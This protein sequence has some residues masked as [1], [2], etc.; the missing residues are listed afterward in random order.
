[1]VEGGPYSLIESGSGHAHRP[2][3]QVK[4]AVTQLTIVIPAPA[5]HAPSSVTPQVCR[6]ACVDLDE[7]DPAEDLPRRDCPRG[8]ASFTPSWDSWFD[9]HTSGG[10]CF[11][12]VNAHLW[13]H[14]RHR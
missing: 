13:N 12:R 10:T 8:S 3:R 5:E 7:G 6:I 2:D 11:S 1:V 4:R 9:P 14:G